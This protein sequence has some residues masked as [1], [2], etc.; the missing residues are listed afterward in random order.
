MNSAK[1]SNCEMLRYYLTENDLLVSLI[2]QNI[3]VKKA[4]VW[5][6]DFLG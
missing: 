4:P 3:S 2:T 5:C 1:D 6:C